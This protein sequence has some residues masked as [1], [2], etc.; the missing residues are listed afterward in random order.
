MRIAMVGPFGLHPKQTMRSRALGLARPLVHRGH[1]VRLFMPPWDT[2]DEADRAWAEDGV[3]L[4]YISL[5]GGVAGITR[6]LVR[7]T[8]AWQPDVVHCFKPKAYSGLAAEWLWCFHRRYVRVIMDTDDWEGPGGWNDIA[9]YSPL[10]KRFFARQERWGLAHNHALTVASRALEGLAASLG[11]S[12]DRIVYVPNGPGIPLGDISPA[13]RAA[14]RTRLGL[15]QRPAVL[16][17][18]RLFEFDSARLAAVLAGVKA[19]LPDLAVLL[20]GAGLFESDADRFRAQL[21]AGG[22]LD[23]VIDAGWTPLEELPATLAA[24]DVGLY[25]MDDTLLNRAKCPVKLADMLAAG[26]PVVGESVGQVAEYILD[27]QTGA[28]VASGDVAGMV[29]EAVVL[30][31]DAGER[32]RRGKAAR[33]DVGE[34][35]DWDKL[36]DRALQAYSDGSGEATGRPLA[37]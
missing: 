31:S 28:L 23:S 29:R 21:A 37:D 1:P 25:M 5:R 14:A 4:R 35:F 18:S 13:E 15:A 36:A 26:V 33:E 9:P 6:S 27:G 3:E 22:L 2:P 10:Q 8:L 34:R 19:Q 7:E 24:A 32:R 20:V 17:Y 30:L 11:V 16:V 12:P